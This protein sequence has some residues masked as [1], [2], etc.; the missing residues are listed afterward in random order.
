M[1]PGLL[2]QQTRVGRDHGKMVVGLVDADL[3]GAIVAS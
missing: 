3:V 1:L 2:L